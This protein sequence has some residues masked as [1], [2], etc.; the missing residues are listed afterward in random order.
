MLG[1]SDFLGYVRT[2][3]NLIL[4]VNRDTD[5]STEFTMLGWTVFGGQIGWNAAC[6]QLFASPCPGIVS[7]SNGVT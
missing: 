3:E 2:G 7:L 5:P 4:G 1:V 6:K